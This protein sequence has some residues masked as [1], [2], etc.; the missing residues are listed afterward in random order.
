MTNSL[1]LFFQINW[2]MGE[3]TELKVWIY[4]KQQVCKKWNKKFKHYLPFKKK[5]FFTFINL[6]LVKSASDICSRPGIEL[7]SSSVVKDK[8]WSFN[9]NCSLSWSTAPW[10][11]N[12]PEILMGFSLSLG[13][14]LWFTLFSSVLIAGHDDLRGLLPKW[15]SDSVNIIYAVKTSQL[16]LTSLYYINYKVINFVYL[17]SLCIIT[18]CDYIIFVCF[19]T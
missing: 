15:F 7:L 18:Y 6:A 13:T 12:C 17:V 14:C 3:D 19:R 4:L 10:L 9:V 1:M 5:L 16:L 11:L 2:I 8:C